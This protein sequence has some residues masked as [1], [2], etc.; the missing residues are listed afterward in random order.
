MNQRPK[1]RISNGAVPI[2]SP[3]GHVFE[4][5]AGFRIHTTAGRSTHRFDVACS[6]DDVAPIFIALV[7]ASTPA[8]PAVGGPRAG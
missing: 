7:E 6:A 5:R 3:D 4:P 8:R 2:Q 1:Y